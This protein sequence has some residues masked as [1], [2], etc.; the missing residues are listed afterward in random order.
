MKLFHFLLFKTGKTNDY[1]LLYFQKI[2][3]VTEMHAFV[4]SDKIQNI[5]E[6]NH[7]KYFIYFTPLSISNL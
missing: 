2:I 4:H 7:V 5:R 3:F 6:K 1:I